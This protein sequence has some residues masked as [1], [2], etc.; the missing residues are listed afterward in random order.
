[1][2]LKDFISNFIDNDTD[3]KIILEWIWQDEGID[4][5]YSFEG[6]ISEF[7]YNY[8]ECYDCLDGYTVC[9][10]SELIIKNK[11]SPIETILHTDIYIKIVK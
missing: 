11:L 8:N 6:K 3:T 1:M 10:V 5:E 2:L 9:D 7:L 4:K